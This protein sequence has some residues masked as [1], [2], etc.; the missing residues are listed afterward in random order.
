[1]TQPNPSDAAA[2]GG[3]H[4]GTQSQDEMGNSISFTIDRDKDIGQVANK[5][6]QAAEWQFTSLSDPNRSPK[7]AIDPGVSYYGSGSL[8]LVPGLGKLMF[9]SSMN[10]ANRGALSLD[11]GQSTF[12]SSLV[13][14]TLGS[15]DIETT[16]GQVLNPL[17]AKQPSTN[18]SPTKPWVKKL[19]PALGNLMGI[20]ILELV[21][22]TLLDSLDSQ[23]EPKASENNERKKDIDIATII[24]DNQE[25][26]DQILGN[27]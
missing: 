19:F 13:G 4:P 10:E 5:I 7:Y 6:L 21:N 11:E 15:L 9:S 20:A 3:A 12:F 8:S 2:I 16:D 18:Y 24:V 22:K 27:S 17:S 25:I 1:M 23:R 14:T 26:E